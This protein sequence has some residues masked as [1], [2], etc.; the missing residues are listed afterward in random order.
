M[1]YVHTV[2]VLVGTTRII[3]PLCCWSTKAATIHT[4][5]PQGTAIFWFVYTINRQTN[6]KDQEIIIIF[7]NTLLKTKLY[8]NI[9]KRKQRNRIK[10][11]EHT[12][13]SNEP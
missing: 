4:F 5:L 8:F 13:E 11:E 10:K 9:Q 6:C 7:L 12:I 3:F 2:C 1:Y